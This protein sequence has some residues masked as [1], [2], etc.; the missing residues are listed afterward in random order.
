MT[1][2]PDGLDIN[3]FDVQGTDNPANFVERWKTPTLVT[4]P[5]GSTEVTCS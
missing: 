5:L 3:F 2:T 1:D 4:A